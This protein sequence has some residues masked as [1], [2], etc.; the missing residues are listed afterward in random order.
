MYFK[1]SASLSVESLGPHLL[2]SPQ[3]VSAYFDA[4]QLG[5]RQ[6]LESDV[7]LTGETGYVS[8][9]EIRELLGK[10]IA[11]AECLTD[12]LEARDAELAKTWAIMSEEVVELREESAE[13]RKDVRTLQ[14]LAF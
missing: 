2:R 12:R 1:R 9:V 11:A 6:S 8:R 14:S 4:R 10:L 5:G 13:M 7:G 3:P